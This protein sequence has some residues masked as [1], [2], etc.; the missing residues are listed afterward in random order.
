MG[1]QISDDV[2]INGFVISC[3]GFLDPALSVGARTKGEGIL[4]TM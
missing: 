4:R 2:E 1:L 3:G